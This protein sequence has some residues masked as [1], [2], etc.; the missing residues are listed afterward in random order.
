[1]SSSNNAPGHPHPAPGGVTSTGTNVM[2][3]QTPARTDQWT[4]GTTSDVFKKC[5]HNKQSSKLF[6]KPTSHDRQHGS[7]HVQDSCLWDCWSWDQ[8]PRSH[9]GVLVTA[10]AVEEGRKLTYCSEKQEC[11]TLQALHT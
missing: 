5:S 9:K 11:V 1:M 3:S 10:E 7:S 6:P 2:P 4:L 8:A